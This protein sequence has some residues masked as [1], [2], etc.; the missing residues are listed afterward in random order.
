MFTPTVAVRLYRPIAL[1]LEARGISSE[2]VFAEFAVPPPMHCGW[3]A[4]VPLPQIAGIWDRLLAVTGDPTFAL[5]AA[6]HVDLTTCDVITYLEANAASVRA[7]LE[8]KLKYLPLITNAVTWTLEMSGGDAELALH[9]CPPRPPLAPVAEYLLAARHVFFTHFGPSN[10]AL[11]AVSFRHAAPADLSEFE[12]V[13][14]VRPRFE[15]ARDQ[16][17]FRATLLEAPMRRRD[18]GL[19]DLLQ[20][21]AEQSL[22]TV[23]TDDSVMGRVRLMLRSGIDPGITEVARRLGMSPRNLQRVLA[24]E[25]TSYLE[26]STETRRAAAERLLLRRELA[27][28]EVSY[29]LGFNDVPAFHRAFVRWTGITPGEFRTRAFAGRVQEPAQGRLDFHAQAPEQSPSEPGVSH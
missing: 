22:H 24:S 15:A 9:E 6:Q 28:A 8:A 4:R 23:P 26:I 10:W 3:D 17:V 14:G 18:E 13:F 12:R 20:R 7:A 21:Y 19:V 16:L 27:I 11:R 1:A 2:E 29:A 5:H 25:G